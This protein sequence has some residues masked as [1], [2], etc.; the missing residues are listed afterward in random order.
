MVV[1]VQLWEYLTADP[2]VRVAA[3]EDLLMADRDDL[4]SVGL[5]PLDGQE[6][7]IRTFLIKIDWDW[8]YQVIGELSP[9]RISFRMTFLY[10]VQRCQN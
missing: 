5:P 7:L 10:Q 1:E 8:L 2:V 3:G 9:E 6:H 4:L